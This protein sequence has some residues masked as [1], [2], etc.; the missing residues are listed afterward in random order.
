[1]FTSLLAWLAFREHRDRRI[2]LGFLAITAGA[3]VLALAPGEPGA[4]AWGPV[5]LVLSACLMWGLDNNLTRR[6]ALGDPVQLAAAKGLIAGLTNSV[7]A[8]ILGARL[9]AAAELAF[10]GI[11][12]LLGYG[13][14]L[15]MFV[16]ALRELGTART[17]AYFS[18]AP[19]IGAAVAVPLLGEPL[20]P[21]LI[22]AGALMGAGVWLHVTERHSHDHEHG[23]LGH[24]H[25]HAHDV[26]HDHH[27]GDVPAGP[28]R[29]WHV[30]GPVRH[31]HPHFPDPHHRHDHPGR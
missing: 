11:V 9:S 16:Y 24:D 4:P 7:A 13:L 26:H 12:G 31:R 29:H 5:A 25:V 8:L 30:H 28:H 17:S 14:S 21:A 10:I 20:T 19:F 2:V 22:V 15:V 1:V 18:V 27:D 23:G 3:A 6:V